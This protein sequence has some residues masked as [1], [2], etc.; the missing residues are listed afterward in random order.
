M[1]SSYEGGFPLLTALG[2]QDVDIRSYS[3]LSVA[4]SD[5]SGD[6]QLE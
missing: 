2:P 1:D 6:R 4:N 3:S 5:S